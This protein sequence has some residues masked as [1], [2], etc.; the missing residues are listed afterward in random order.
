MTS[1]PISLPPLCLGDAGDGGGHGED[2][3][4]DAQGPVQGQHP[5]LVPG[6]ALRLGTL[7]HQQTD[8]SKHH[9][10]TSLNQ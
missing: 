2:E 10:C 1:Q 9:L 5:G 3:G 7:Q 8:Q 4:G 6:P